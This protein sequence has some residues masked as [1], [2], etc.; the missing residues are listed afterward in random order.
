MNLQASIVKM[1]PSSNGAGLPES[2]ISTEG[3]VSGILRSITSQNYAVSSNAIAVNWTPRGKAWSDGASITINKGTFI[4]NGYQVT[5]NED[6][7]INTT[8]MPQSNMINLPNESS[9]AIYISLI[10]SLKMAD[11]SSLL[12]ANN[13]DTALAIE[14]SMGVIDDLTINDLLLCKLQCVMPSGVLK[15]NF[16]QN[17]ITSPSVIRLDAQH[18]GTS[19]GSLEDTIN[20]LNNA[21]STETENRTTA[22]TT[23]QTNIDNEASARESADTSI[24]TDMLDKNKS[25]QVV[26]ESFSYGTSNLLHAANYDA[27]YLKIEG[28]D[29][30]AGNPE[31]PNL[32]FPVLFNPLVDTSDNYPSPRYVTPTLSNYASY[33]QNFFKFVGICPNDVGRMGGSYWVVTKGLVRFYHQYNYSSGPLSFV[34]ENSNDVNRGVLIT[35]DIPSHKVGDVVC[36]L[37][38]T[39]TVAAV[40]A[41]GN[42]TAD[43]YKPVLQIIASQTF[44][45]HNHYATYLNS[46][47]DYM[48]GYVYNVD[49]N[50]SNPYT[51]ILFI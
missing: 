25:R 2:R 31:H 41:S 19:S 13:N 29:N 34:I 32:N 51:D 38:H 22:D 40:K 1:Y 20:N 5:L 46:A 26:D 24:R 6:I 33:D 11:G 30:T 14:L 36:W 27:V 28:I 43:N 7:V 45:N 42:W 16:P 37:T 21:I 49:T 44:T 4:I 23:L 3:N 47:S 39:Q 48:V 15:K 12:K 50:S 8:N 10:M 35:T 18:I 9:S 17:D